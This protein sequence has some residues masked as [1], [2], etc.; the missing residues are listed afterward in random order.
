MKSGFCFGGLMDAVSPSDRLNHLGRI[1]RAAQFGLQENMHDESFESNQSFPR[2]LQP[3]SKF[4]Q[5]EI[6]TGDIT[7]IR[8]K[9]NK[10]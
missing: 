7:H 10:S 3:Q 6:M 1:E 8:G 2:A 4:K 5:T 9:Q